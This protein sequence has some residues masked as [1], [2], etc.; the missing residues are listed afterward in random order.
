MPRFNHCHEPEQ[1]RQILSVPPL[2]VEGM[3]TTA[4]EESQEAAK[5]LLAGEELRR[6][7]EAM[8]IRALCTLASTY[9]LEIEELI[10]PLAERL[11]RVGG[12][13]TP[14]VSEHLRLEV[15]GLLGCGPHVAAGKL[16]DAVNLRYRHPRLYEAVQELRIDAGR[17]LQAARRCSE[18]DATVTDAVT[19]RWLRHQEGLGWGAAFN[20]L[21]RLIIEADQVWAEEKE[22]KARAERSVCVWGLYEGVMNLS[23][24]LDVLDARFLDVRLDEFARLL[25]ERFPTLTHAQRRAKA[26]AVLANPALALALLQESA[27]AELPL[28]PADPDCVLGT[29]A[30][31]PASPDGLASEP[32]LLGGVALLNL[33]PGWVLTE[34]LD[35]PPASEPGAEQRPGTDFVGMTLPRSGLPLADEALRRSR[36]VLGIAVHIHSDAVGDLQGAAR[37]EKAGHIT[38]ALLAEL[39]GEGAGVALRVYPVIDLPELDP[40]DSYV[41]GTVMRRAVCL[42]FANEPFPFSNRCSAGLDLDHTEAFQ[43]GRRGQTRLGNLGPL[44]RRVHRAKT[45]GFWGLSQPEPGCMVWTSPLGY[46]YLVTPLGTFRVPAE[47]QERHHGPRRRRR[48]AARHPQN[49]PRR[50]G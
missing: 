4:F 29:V 6:R 40:A 22:H 45:A 9:R 13:G 49:H 30:A 48:R 47:A 21:D 23:G 3:R 41:P 5:E 20:L 7:G 14:A 36:P 46:R 27:Q 26:V 16:A 33:P 8:T 38:T 34:G 1:G 18:V 42:A 43:P 11:V 24:K 31:G 15:Q 28:A 25:E 37:V 32:H 17:A 39:L 19:A 10:A 35:E 44:T 12:E 2:R 50:S